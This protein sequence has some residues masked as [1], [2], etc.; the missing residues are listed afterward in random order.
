MLSEAW[1]SGGGH[2]SAIAQESQDGAFDVDAAL[3]SRHA[4]AVPI[5]PSVEARGGDAHV[6]PA[7]VVQVPLQEFCHQSAPPFQV[8]HPCFKQEQVAH[9]RGHAFGD[10]PQFGGACLGEI[11]GRPFCRANA[12][13]VPSVV[14]FVAGDADDFHVAFLRLDALGRPQGDDRAVFVFHA[15]TDVAVWKQVEKMVLLGGEKTQNG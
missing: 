8:D 5:Q 2:D 4:E 7:R 12:F 6:E 14:Q 9:V 1:P 10:V 3:A 11:V 15:V 13:D